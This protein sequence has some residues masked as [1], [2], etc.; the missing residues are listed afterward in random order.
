MKHSRLFLFLFASAFAVTA[1]SQENAPSSPPSSTQAILNAL[2]PDLA[3]HEDIVNAAMM[4]LTAEGFHAQT[5]SAVMDATATRARTNLQRL[6]RD[7][8]ESSPTDP[9]AFNQRVK[10]ARKEAQRLFPEVDIAGSALSQRVIQERTKLERIYPDYFKN[11]DW[12]LMLTNG[13]IAAMTLEAQEKKAQQQVQANQSP[14]SIDQAKQTV[15]L[16]R[17]LQD[18][19]DSRSGTSQRR[20]QTPAEADARWQQYQQQRKL[21]Q[22]QSEINRL[23]QQ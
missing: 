4:A 9:V 2:Y 12:P 3:A 11:P 19:K 6:K 18:L 14:M 23:R 20:Q 21:Q 1:F 16:L 7:S 13:C 22:M 8:A 10:A 17:M 5:L 15:E